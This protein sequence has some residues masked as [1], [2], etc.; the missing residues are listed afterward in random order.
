MKFIVFSTGFVQVVKGMGMPNHDFPSERGDLFVT[1]SVVF[2]AS[3]SPEQ[4]KCIFLFVFNE[5]I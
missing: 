1:Y 2:P 4:I 3:L 5:F